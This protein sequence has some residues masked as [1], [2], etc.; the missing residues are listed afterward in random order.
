MDRQCCVLPNKNWIVY[1]MTRV[2]RIIISVLAKQRLKSVSSDK[3]RCYFFSLSCN[4]IYIG[5][6]RGAVSGI[7]LT[8][9]CRC[10]T[11]GRFRGRR[12]GRAPVSAYTSSSTSP[13]VS[14][15]A[16]GARSRGTDRRAFSTPA[17]H[18]GDASSSSA[19]A[20]AAP[21]AVGR[22]H[23]RSRRFHGLAAVASSF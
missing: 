11:R 8:S 14:A 13:A 10:T 20:A 18:A 22:R 5:G 12:R 19:A 23:F 6:A 4:I 17:S 15:R 3:I 21:R 16:N 7:G 1:P 2:H 9:S